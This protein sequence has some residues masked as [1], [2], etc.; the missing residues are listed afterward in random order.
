M[1]GRKNEA[2]AILR[3]A[4]KKDPAH[5]VLGEAVKKFSP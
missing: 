3:E 4:Q 1:L 5:E 2:Q